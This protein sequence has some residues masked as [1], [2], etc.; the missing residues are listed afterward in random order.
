MFVPPINLGQFQPSPA[1]LADWIYQI[2]NYLQNNPI[3]TQEQLQEYIA[4]FIT[5]SPETQELI[6]EGVEQYLIDNPPEAPVQSVQGKTGTVTLAYNDIVTSSNTIPVYKAS[7]TPSTSTLVGQYNLGYRLFVNTATHEI[8][9][10]SNTGALTLVGKGVFDGT[11]IDLD[12]EQ[13]DTT[14][15]EAVNEVSGRVDTLGTS[16]NI[17]AWGNYAASSTVITLSDSMENYDVIIFQSGSQT[18]QTAGGGAYFSYAFGPQV[19]Q[20]YGGMFQLNGDFV[21]FSVRFVSATTIKVETAYN[22]RTN[23]AYTGT[24]VRQILGLKLT[25]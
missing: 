4:T 1:T 21:A 11:D 9:S 15:A 13:G 24:V 18:D 6:G 12:T 22:C 8:Y 17:L 3:A 2:W 14:I 19:G 5:T 7:S 23:A 10:I 25:A 20:A 16:T